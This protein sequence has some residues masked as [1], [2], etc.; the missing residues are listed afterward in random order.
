[1][2]IH[3][4]QVFLARDDIIHEIKKIT[5]M[6][7]MEFDGKNVK[8]NYINPIFENESNAMKELKMFLM[9]IKES[10]YA[11]KNMRTSDG[12]MDK[13]RRVNSMKVNF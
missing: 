8:G 3:L 6:A 12:Y 7:Y 11:I 9:K 13:V 5:A 1:M 2:I 4:H 10:V